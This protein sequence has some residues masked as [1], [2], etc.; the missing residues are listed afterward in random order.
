MYCRDNSLHCTHEKP[1]DWP[2]YDW[3]W[4]IIPTIM[5]VFAVI[6]VIGSILFGNGS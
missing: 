4:A 5:T 3:G 2:P 6:S 1:A